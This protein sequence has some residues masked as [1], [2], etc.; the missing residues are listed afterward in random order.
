M[1]KKFD[2][3]RFAREPLTFVKICWPDMKLTEYQCEILESVWT[4]VG[5]FVHAANGVGKTR[6][7]AIWFMATR[8][9]PKSS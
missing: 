3:S 2:F 9:L 8:T 5:T 6:I 4:N 1:K 7:A